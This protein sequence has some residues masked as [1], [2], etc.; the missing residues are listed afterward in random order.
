[1]ASIYSVVSTSFQPPVGHADVLSCGLT[2]FEVAASE[3][4]SCKNGP[5]SGP[6]RGGLLPPFAVYT[7]GLVDQVNTFEGALEAPSSKYRVLEL[8]SI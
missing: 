5:I 2:L 6:L 3:S 8:L 7:R 1:M 4:I